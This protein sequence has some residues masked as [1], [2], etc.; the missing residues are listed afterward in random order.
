MAERKTQLND[1]DVKTFLGSVK[2]E[3]RRNDSFVVA[4]L[5]EA[6]SGVKPQMWGPSIVGFGTHHYSYADGRPAEICRIGLYVNRLEDVDL[7]VLETIFEKAYEHREQD[8]PDL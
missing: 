2:N 8:N 7:S 1:A 4:E 6:T 5:M 3:K